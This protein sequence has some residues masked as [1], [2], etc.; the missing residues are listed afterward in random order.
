MTS[1]E[2]L[3][4]LNAIGHR[5]LT[6]AAPLLCRAMDIIVASDQPWAGSA[7]HGY[8]RP[9]VF[10]AAGRCDRSPGNARPIR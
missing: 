4:H 2:E 6:G 10:S 8:Q 9:L 5:G 1:A 7:I 3:E